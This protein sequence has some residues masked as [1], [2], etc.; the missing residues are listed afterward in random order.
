MHGFIFLACTRLVPLFNNQDTGKETKLIFLHKGKNVDLEAFIL[1]TFYFWRANFYQSS[2]K[3]PNKLIY[4]H[5]CAKL[6][7]SLG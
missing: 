2:K 5:L 4:P 1:N 6:E 3:F 7:T